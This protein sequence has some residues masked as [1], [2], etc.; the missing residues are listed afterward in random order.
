MTSRFLNHSLS[1][2]FNRFLQR[3]AWCL[4]TLAAASSVAQAAEADA[5]YQQL[6]QKPGISRFVADFVTIITTDTRISKSFAE[7]DQERLAALLTEQFCQLSGGPCQYSGRS[8]EVTHA[9]MQITNA[10]FNALAEDLQIAMEKHGIPSQAQ[11][12][13]L[14]KL[15]PM[16]RAIVEK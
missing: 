12:K 4:I 1:R 8:M 6:G 13:L 16:Q 14:A 10:Q 11:N 3:A 7:T 15:A 9:K 2:F 5:L